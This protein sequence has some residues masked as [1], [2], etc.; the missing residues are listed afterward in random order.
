MGERAAGWF[1]RNRTRLSMDESI[2]AVERIYLSSSR[3][4]FTNDR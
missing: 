1:D 3:A 4:A 2:E